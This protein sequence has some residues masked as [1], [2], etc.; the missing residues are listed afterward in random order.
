MLHVKT[1]VYGVAISSLKIT[2]ILQTT[3]SDVLIGLARAHGNKLS[4]SNQV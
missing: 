4:Y 2:L 3:R 1:P